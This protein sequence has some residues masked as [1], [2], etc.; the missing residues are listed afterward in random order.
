M[1]PVELR[2]YWGLGEHPHLLRCGKV[3]GTGL[4][5]LQRWI[6]L[7]RAIQPAY[8]LVAQLRPQVVL[9]MGGYIVAPTLLAARRMNIPIL[10]HESNAVAGRTTRLFSRWAKLVLLAHPDARKCF[11]SRVQTRI[12]GTPVRADL[13]ALGREKGAAEFSLDPSRR[14]LLVLGGSQGARAMNFVLLEALRSLDALAESVG[15]L[16]VL[17]STGAG[18]HAEI[19]SALK[20]APPRHLTVRAYPTIQRMDAAYAAANLVLSRAGAGTIAEITALGLPSI[21]V[22]YPNAKDDHQRQNARSLAVS[23]AT[24]LVE[25]RQLT[26]ESLTALLQSL[27]QQEELLRR[28]SQAAQAQAMPR[29]AEDVADALITFGLENNS[30]PINSLKKAVSC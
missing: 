11:R 27:F 2:T 4:G 19:S 8:R 12:V 17:W 21:L 3:P 28:M 30:Q 14:T 24:Q 1:R 16:Q 23:G 6:Q 22:P 18:N 7:A 9:G 15:G 20:D 13:F 10:L 29:A 25:E 26:P 5:G